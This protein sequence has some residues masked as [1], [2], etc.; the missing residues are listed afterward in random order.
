MIVESHWRR[1]KHDYL[2]QFN[3]PRIDLVT[4]I[5]ISQAVPRSMEKMRAILEGNTRTNP[6]GW[7]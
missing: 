7:R 3:W 4:W 6:L 1:L 2:H 5:I